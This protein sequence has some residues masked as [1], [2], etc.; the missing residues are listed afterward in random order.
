MPASIRIADAASALIWARAPA[1]SVRFTASASP[2]SGVALRSRSCASQETGGA[3]SA[4]MTKRPARSRSAKV[5]GRGAASI[6]HGKLALGTRGRDKS[7]YMLCGFTA[8]ARIARFG[9]RFWTGNT[10]DR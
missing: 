7:A 10:V 2:R 5:R 9:R 8:I 3:T 4:V 6:G 1:P